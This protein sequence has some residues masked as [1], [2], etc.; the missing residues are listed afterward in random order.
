M[1]DCDMD[2]TDGAKLTS[3]PKTAE[4]DPWPVVFDDPPK[5]GYRVRCKCRECNETIVVYYR[6][7]EIVESDG[8][9]IWERGD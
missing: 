1:T 4:I 9:V 8:T 2:H 7:E 3:D 5:S 6:Q